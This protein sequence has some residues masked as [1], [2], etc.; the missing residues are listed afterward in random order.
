MAQNGAAMSPSLGV[1]F[2]PTGSHR[3]TRWAMSRAA[4]LAT[5]F[6]SAFACLLGAA[7]MPAAAQSAWMTEQAMRGAFIGKT[8]DGHYA[9]GAD[10][11]ESYGAD[12]RLGYHDRKHGKVAGYWYFRDRVFCTIYDP[13]Q[14]IGGGCFTA[15]Q[16]SANCYA[17]YTAGL[18]DREADGPPPGPT[19][20]WV[21]RASR[22]G[23]LSTC[24]AR[25]TV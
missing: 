18:G 22:R 12:G 6:F 10:W 7:G 19:G 16:E 17:F 20:R 2:A 13:G 11:T 5:A 9:D 14:L 21:A 1:K 4:R 3:L 8:L 24:E 15:L 25:P 23:E